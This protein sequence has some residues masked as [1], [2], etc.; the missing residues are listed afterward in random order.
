MRKPKLSHKKIENILYIYCCFIGGAAGGGYSQ[1]IPMEEV[2]LSLNQMQFLLCKRLILSASV[3]CIGLLFQN[4]L[5]F[6]DLAFYILYVTQADSSLCDR[7]AMA[8]S[9][10]VA[11][12]GWCQV[13][14]KLFQNT[15]ISFYS[16]W[17]LCALLVPSSSPFLYACHQGW[18]NPSNFCMSVSHVQWCLA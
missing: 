11:I 3:P 4:N 14:R 10:S 9:C 1:V 5:L 17:S 16:T 7:P 12:C 13:G 8:V 15:R 2:M 6:L 18:A